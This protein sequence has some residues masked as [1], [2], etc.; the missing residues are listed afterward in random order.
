MNLRARGE[1]KSGNVEGVYH[2]R[3]AVVNVI[4]CSAFFEVSDG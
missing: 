1:L 4:N 2:S 3:I